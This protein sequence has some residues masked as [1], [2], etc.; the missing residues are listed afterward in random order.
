MDAQSKEELPGA[1]S[2]FRSFQPPGRISKKDLPQPSNRE[3]QTSEDRAK[4]EID[5]S[6]WYLTWEDDM[7]QPP[8]QTEVVD[9]FKSA[10][11]VLSEERSWQK[12]RIGVDEFFAWVKEEPLVRISPDLSL[13][14]DPPPPPYPRMW[15]TWEP[16]INPP[17]FALEVVSDEWQK[18]YLHNPTKYD[19][20]GTSELVI[21]DPVAARGQ[22]R[23]PRRS[24]L[25]V[26]RRGEDGSFTRIYQGSGPVESRELGIWLVVWFDRDMA[27][28]RLSRDPE[29]KELIP[30]LAEAQVLEQIAR[31]RAEQKQAEE[32]AARQ[33]AEQKQAEERAARQAAE[34]KQAEERA[35]RQAA[36]QN[37][38]EERAARQAAEQNQAEAEQKQ[39]E[40]RSAREELERK[41]AEALAALERSRS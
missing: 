26:Y 2:R 9:N 1:T 34:Q 15:Q 27:W 19:Q 41:L 6:D 38:A 8:E 7:G 10:V 14:D 28:L 25:E 37:Q 39:A 36:E 31:R 18:D 3:P 24:A 40:E 5:W 22:T 13:M 30:T 12:V 35:A 16:G 23:S 21:F 11:T 4:G 32:R 33:A 29:G 17:R 20:L